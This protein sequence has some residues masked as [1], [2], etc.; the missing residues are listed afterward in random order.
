MDWNTRYESEDYLFGTAPTPF[1]TRHAAHLPEAADLLAVADGEGRN[2]VWLAQQGHQVSAFDISDNALAKAQRLAEA[3]DVTVSFV[4]AGI[5]DWDWQAPRYDAIA[6]IFIQF[7]GPEPRAA[8]FQRFDRVL[9]PGGVLLLHGFAPRQ[10]G[11]GTGGPPHVEKM[12]TLDLLRQ[13]FPDYAVLAEADYDEEISSGR[14]HNG[15]AGLIDFVA[16]KPGN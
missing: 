6:A 16:Q 7:M 11:Y 14:G 15:V 13:S 4:R 1:V 3:A 5:D 10:V 9:R 2:S 8:L 12:Y